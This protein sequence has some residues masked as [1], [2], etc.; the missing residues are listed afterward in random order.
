MS[1]GYSRYVWPD[2]SSGNILDGS[3]ASGAPV[4]DLT[5]EMLCPAF[6]R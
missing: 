4:V 5:Y 6:T 2:V 3:S 1:Y